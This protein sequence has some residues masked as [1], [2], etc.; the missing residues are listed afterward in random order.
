LRRDPPRGLD[1]GRHIA[2]IA[3]GEVLA[4]TADLKQ[5]YVDVGPGLLEEPAA[6]V[7]FRS[8]STGARDLNCHVAHVDRPAARWMLADLEATTAVQ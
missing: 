1:R 4:M 7:M 3:P 6:D 5:R 8:S 2:E